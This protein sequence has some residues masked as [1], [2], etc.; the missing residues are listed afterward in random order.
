MGRGIRQG[1]R[2]IRKEISQKAPYELHNE[3]KR[4]RNIGSLFSPKSP[5]CTC[6]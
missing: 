4:L 6:A 2:M 3:K 5:L 1:G